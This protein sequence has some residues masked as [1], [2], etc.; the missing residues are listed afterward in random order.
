MLIPVILLLGAGVIGIYYITKTKGRRE[1]I[2]KK[3]SR[4]SNPIRQ[5]KYAQD[6]YVV[7]PYYPFVR[8]GIVY[9]NMYMQRKRQQN[10]QIAPTYRRTSGI[11]FIEPDQYRKGNILSLRRTYSRYPYPY[12]H[13]NQ[14]TPSSPS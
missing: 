2:P 6:D 5:Y 10:N 7:I 12:I 13:T 8:P 3:E 11:H 1:D 9:S 14:Q 4:L